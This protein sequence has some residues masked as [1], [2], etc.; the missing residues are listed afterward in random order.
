MRPHRASVPGAR[1][2]LVDDDSL[3]ANALGRL[4]TS[5]G[6]SVITATTAREALAALESDA[7]DLVVCDVMM[8]SLDGIEL[9]RTVRVTRAWAEIPV[10]LV[11]G[12]EDRETRVRAQEV[13][14]CFLLKPVDTLE[15]CIVIDRLL[16]RSRQVAALRRE[17]ARLH[18]ELALAASGPLREMG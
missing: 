4:L 9:A 5:Q 8:T 10:I 1:I 18:E 13:A 2:M 6:Y 14:D 7:P 12:L 15:L 17:N 3:V 16:G 11:S